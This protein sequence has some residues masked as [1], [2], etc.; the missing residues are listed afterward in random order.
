MS[1]TES[2]SF[3]V[4][5]KMSGSNNRARILEEGITCSSTNS[6]EVAVR[7][8]LAKLAL[9]NGY[10]PVTIRLKTVTRSVNDALYLA[11]LSPAAEARERSAAE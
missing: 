1:L 9:R 7:G 4:A 2:V 8:A 11:T 6:A 3:T 10:G 5:V